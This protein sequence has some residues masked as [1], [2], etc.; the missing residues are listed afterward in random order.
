MFEADEAWD[1]V[2]DI[3]RGEKG[4]GD[5][6]GCS[7]VE[8]SS[9][10]SIPAASESV[11]CFLGRMTLHTIRTSSWLANIR[12]ITVPIEAIIMSGTSKAKADVA[13]KLRTRAT[14]QFVS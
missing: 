10:A 6:G 9:C 11:N 8:G 1:S 2:S 3:P 5:E 13:T 4:V 14:Y 7:R 12:K